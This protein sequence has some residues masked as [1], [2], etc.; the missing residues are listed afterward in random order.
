MKKQAG[1]SLIELLISI[2]VG[3]VVLG[4]LGV[5][6]VSGLSGNKMAD[7]QSQMS[8]DAQ[9]ALTVITRQIQQAGFVSGNTAGVDR[10]LNNGGMVFFACDAGFS[11]AKSID[12][13]PAANM[14]L[15]TCNNTN[16]PTG[17][18]ASFAV[19]YEA[20]IVNTK[21]VGSVPNQQ[22]T[23]C[24]GSGVTVV[25]G[26]TAAVVEN[27]FYLDNGTLYC[28]GN[29][30]GTTTFNN[31]QAIVNNIESMQFEFGMATTAVPTQV[32][33]FVTRTAAIGPANIA[34]A[35]P[36]SN[37]TLAAVVGQP[38][39][40]SVNT[41]VNPSVPVMSAAI[42]ANAQ[43]WRLVHSV[44]VCLI[45]TS[46]AAVSKDVAGSSANPKYYDCQG[47]LTESTDGRVR[48]AYGTSVVLR[49]LQN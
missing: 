3:L 46:V 21:P 12:A 23:D 7:A 43:R 48:K 13:S 25:A 37:V 11:N 22:P 10:S 16:N 36:A 35:T 39:R 28:T 17:G 1:F 29:G 5:T 38:M 34:D 33:G 47:A 9:V 40:L 49:N 44:R 20:D 8:E 26:T 27:R 2:T 31:L 18:S 24:T 14:S 30:G 4:V 6:Y 45:A 19:A 15:L 32:A 41:A 42:S